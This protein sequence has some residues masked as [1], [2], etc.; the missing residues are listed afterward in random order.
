MQ[1]EEVETGP[2]P[3]GL[4]IVAWRKR[5]WCGQFDPPMANTTFYSE[6]SLE[7]IDIV[8]VGSASWVTTTSADYLRRRQAFNEAGKPAA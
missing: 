8:K 1:P 4:Q 7:L 2:G 3:T 5:V 6:V